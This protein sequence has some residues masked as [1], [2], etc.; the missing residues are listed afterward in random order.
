MVSDNNAALVAIVQAKAPL[1]LGETSRHLR[2][3]DAL[4]QVDRAAFLPPEMRPSAYVDAAL[5]I[6]FGQTCSQPSMVAFMLDEL[7]IHEGQRILEVGAGCGYAAAV[8]SRL[9]GDSGTVFAAEIIP[10]LAESS[11]HNLRGFA[12]VQVVTADGSIGLPAEAPFD[13]IFLSAGIAAFD[14]V[15]S[16][17]SE[18][19]LLNQLAPGGILLFPEARG[20]IYKIQKAE[21][22]YRVRKFYGVSFVP[23]VGENS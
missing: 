23:L 2:V 7:D 1:Y 19:I 17:F 9:C 11:R 20:S 10:E 4:L 8:V 22:G 13:R 6:G 5:Q 16:R 15:G 3:L 12:N 14:A 21:D 18:R